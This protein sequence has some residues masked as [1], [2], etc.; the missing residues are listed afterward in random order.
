MALK[1]PQLQLFTLYSSGA[2]I[3]D[4]TLV[5]SSFK[6]IDGMNL[7]MTDFGTKGFMTLDPGAG[8]LEEQIS[9]TGVTQNAN[10]T[11][12]LSGVCTVLMLSPYTETSGIAK[13]HS[14][15]STASVSITSGLL[16]QFTNKN[17]NETVTGTWS[18]PTYT[19]SDLYQPAT[20][21]Y[22]TGVAMAGAVNAST[23]VKGIVEIATGD[24]LAAGTATGATGAVVVAAAS[25]CKSSSA[26]AGDANKLPVTDANG[27]IDQTFLNTARTIGAV[28]SATAD[29][30]QITTDANSANDAVRQSYLQAEISKGYTTGTAGETITVGQALYLKAVDGK[31][32]K[33]AGTADETTFSFVGIAVSAGNANNTIYYARPGDVATGLAGLTAGS[34]YY[35]TDT[36]GTL[37]TTPGTRFAKVG[38]ALSTTT[39]RVC[40]PKFYVTGVLNLTALGDTVVTTGFYPAK[41]QLLSAGNNGSV[42][43]GSIGTEANVAL[44]VLASTQY[45]DTSNCI[46]VTDGGGSLIGQISAK[47]A[48]GFTVHVSTKTSTNG[49]YVRYMAESL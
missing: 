10:G 27:A 37:G 35:V 5:L 7:A 42:A 39:L 32:W 12:T 48:T 40:E 33:A 26:G 34:Y 28:Y 46:Y 45:Y 9:F 18:F 22:V 21:E 41:I 8:S 13:Q 16:N 6:T 30:L 43:V 4:V 19:S 31:L 17:D 47:S 24:E 44:Q 15:G 20:I 25:S 1:Y 3:G 2:T 29:N 14:G 11:A 36:A 49:A 23:T 38:Q